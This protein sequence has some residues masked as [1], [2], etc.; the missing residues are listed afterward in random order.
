[1]KSS[2]RIVLLMSI[3]FIGLVS[4]KDK[5]PDNSTS[6]DRATLLT[7]VA[8]SIIIPRYTTLNDLSMDFQTA[9]NDYCLSPNSSSLQNAKL[10]WLDLYKAWQHCKM[11]D[12]G[13][14]MDNSL[15]RRLNAFPS[16]TVRIEDN[17]SV[18]TYNLDL[19]DVEKGVY[20]VSVKSEEETIIKKIVI[21]SH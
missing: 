9:V 3:G 13:P 15:L 11:Y 8:D 20:F 21:M 18:G 19:Q 14:A 1:M 4:C 6:F 2:L 10:K 16:D 5:A 7:N 17:I 12:F